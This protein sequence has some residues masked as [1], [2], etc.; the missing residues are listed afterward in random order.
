MFSL[1]ITVISIAL[2]AALALATLYFGGD[3]FNQ[4]SAKAGAATLVNH[5]SQ[6][7]GA[8]TLFFLDNQDYAGVTAGAS[9]DLVPDYL[10]AVPNPGNIA[11]EYAVTSGASKILAA[12]VSTAVCDALNQQAGVPDSDATTDGYQHGITAEADLDAYQFGC[13][14]DTGT[15]TFVYK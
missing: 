11:G 6:I 13:F 14:D 7:S 2:V 10:A 9:A 5:A 3:A 4:G 8:N 12:D 15:L 1:I